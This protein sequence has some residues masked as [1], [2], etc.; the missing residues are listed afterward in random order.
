M[1]SLQ[2]QLFVDSPIDM[3]LQKYNYIEDYSLC[4]HTLYIK[5]NRELCQLE[6]IP[7]RIDLYKFDSK[8]KLHI[9]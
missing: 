6:L 9:S 5:I 8:L 4:A 3:L 7:L 2:V 1:V